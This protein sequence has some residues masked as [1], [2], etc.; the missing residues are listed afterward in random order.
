MFPA[1]TYHILIVG[2]LAAVKPQ[3]CHMLLAAV[4]DSMALCPG[5]LGDVGQN[6]TDVV[7]HC[8]C[9]LLI[10]GASQIKGAS[11]STGHKHSKVPPYQCAVLTKIH[12]HGHLDTAVWL[13]TQLPTTCDS[14]VGLLQL[15]PASTHQ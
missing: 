6:S 13:H 15:L 7:A 3:H 14:T 9:G 4:C 5:D 12:H 1:Q 8:W 2:G 11:Q 10:F